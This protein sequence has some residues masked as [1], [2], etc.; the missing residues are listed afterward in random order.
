MY[1]CPNGLGPHMII[2]GVVMGRLKHVLSRESAPSTTRICATFVDAILASWHACYCLGK[3]SP[4]EKEK[5]KKNLAHEGL[6]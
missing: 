2:L 1:C 5:E 6:D 3:L 4:I